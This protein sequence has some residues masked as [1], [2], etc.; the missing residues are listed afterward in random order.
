M[1]K[2]YSYKANLDGEKVGK[3]ESNLWTGMFL[4]LKLT[5]L[6]DNINIRCYYNNYIKVLCYSFL[7]PSLRV[8]SFLLK[9][10]CP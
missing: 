8:V 7:L 5:L 10:C 3:A 9:V 1:Y 6:I 4:R 2:K